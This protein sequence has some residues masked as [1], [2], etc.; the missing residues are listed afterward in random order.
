[1]LKKIQS[2]FKKD[3]CLCTCPCHNGGMVMLHIVACC[4]KCTGCGK[5][6]LFEKTEEHESKCDNNNQNNDKTKSDNIN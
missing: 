4:K 5:N 6:I 1:M 3:P 2:Y